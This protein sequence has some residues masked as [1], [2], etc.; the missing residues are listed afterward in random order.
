MQFAD[1]VF[2]EAEDRQGNVVLRKPHSTGS[3]YSGS[4]ASRGAIA[5]VDGSLRGVSFRPLG[6]S[7]LV[8]GL[9]CAAG[10]RA[11]DLAGSQD[12]SSIDFGTYLERDGMFGVYELG[13]W[14]GWFGNYSAGN[15][16][17]VALS[18]EGRVMYKVSGVVRYMSEVTPAFPLHAKVVASDVGDLVEQ[19]QWLD[20]ATTSPAQPTHERCP[21]AF[22]ELG[23]Q[24]QFGMY[25]AL[26][27][28]SRRNMELEG[29]VVDLTEQTNLSKHRVEALES[30]LASIVR[31][32]L[33]ACERCHEEEMASLRAAIDA[34]RVMLQG[35]LARRDETLRGM[36]LAFGE[37]LA[38]MKHLHEE[39]QQRQQVAMARLREDVLEVFQS[40]SEQLITASCTDYLIPRATVQDEPSEC[41]QGEFVVRRTIR[42]ECPGV[43]ETGVSWEEEV[44]GQGLTL[45]LCRSAPVGCSGLRA[46]PRRSDTL[47]PAQFFELSGATFRR[48]FDFQDGPFYLQEDECNLQNGILTL[49]LKKSLC[50]RRGGLK[51]KQQR[52]GFGSPHPLSASNCKKNISASLTTDNDGHSI[53]DDSPAVVNADADFNRG[54]SGHCL[55]DRNSDHSN[56]NSNL[57]DNS[58]N[59]NSNT[60]GNPNS[61]SRNKKNTTDNVHNDNSSRN[62]GSN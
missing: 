25:V 49:V 46:T 2:L 21:T 5:A 59:N 8:L 16:V 13:A 32:R 52:L 29:K 36:L 10:D 27:T 60:Y 9:A 19:V 3:F 58:S 24:E 14:R 39:G 40:W 54:H 38:A 26:A 12:M 62:D 18:G 53:A 43:D 33:E 22:E 47:M 4:A 50:T 11:D 45:N 41:F 23:D 35:E 37:Q 55:N 20:Q 48:V 56:A 34:E 1:L 31:Q 57:N 44:G 30:Q 61:R 17:E 7:Q 6:T 51:I 28:T 42:V 15:R